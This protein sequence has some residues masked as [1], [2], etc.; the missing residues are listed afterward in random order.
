MSK[1]IP[2]II[3]RSQLARALGYTSYRNVSFQSYL[4]DVL[5]EDWETVFRV[6][7]TQRF[8]NSVQTKEII[9]RLKLTA[10]NF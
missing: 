2:A 6:Q 10:E 4:E 3:N 9:E 1:S 7:K 8:F 5:G